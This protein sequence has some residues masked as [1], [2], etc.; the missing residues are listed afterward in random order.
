MM[1]LTS[2]YAKLFW[3]PLHNPWKCLYSELNTVNIISACFDELLQVRKKIWVLLVCKSGPLG[4]KSV[5][6]Q[7]CVEVWPPVPIINWCDDSAQQ[8][9]GWHLDVVQQR[10]LLLGVLDHLIVKNRISQVEQSVINTSS[11]IDVF[12]VVCIKASHTKE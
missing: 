9:M 10:V 5:L 4:L 8:T 3:Y 7:C 11:H 6:G 2:I 12:N 1:Y